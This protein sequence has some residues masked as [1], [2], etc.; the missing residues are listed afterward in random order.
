MVENSFKF[1]RLLISFK[2]YKAISTSTIARWLKTVLNLAGIDTSIFSAHSYRGAL[3]S[4][5]FSSGISLNDILKTANW[6][7]A[8][9]F[10][11]FYNRDKISTDSFTKVVL[12]K[13]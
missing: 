3:T 9:T 7:N 1:G 4:K 12:S 8:E 5:A 11:K 13:D 6:S 10:F 2:T